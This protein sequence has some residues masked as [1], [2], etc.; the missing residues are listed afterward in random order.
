MQTTCVTTFRLQNQTFHQAQVAFDTH[1]NPVKVSNFLFYVTRRKK[2]FGENLKFKWIPLGLPLLS[3]SYSY[4]LLCLQHAYTQICFNKTKK[5]KTSIWKCTQKNEWKPIKMLSLSF[6]IWIAGIDAREMAPLSRTWI[7]CVLGN[8]TRFLVVLLCI[9]V[10]L[11]PGNVEI[12][13]K[14]FHE[15]FISTTCWLDLSS[16]TWCRGEYTSRTTTTREG[17]E[18]LQPNEN[19]W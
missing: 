10:S 8:F 17:C 9:W 6:S 2:S 3:Y 4:S 15:W 7:S 13:H 1:S 18:H 5:K 12:A 19:M 11:N 16:R 14:K